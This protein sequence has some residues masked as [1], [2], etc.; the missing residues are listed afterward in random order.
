MTTIRHH[1][2]TFRAFAYISRKEERPSRDGPLVLLAA[3]FL[4][5][6]HCNG[7]AGFYRCCGRVRKKPAHNGATVIDPDRA[8][9]RKH[10]SSEARLKLK[11]VNTHCIYIPL[12][13]RRPCATVPMAPK[14]KKDPCG[15]F[16]ILGGC[17]L[18]CCRPCGRG[19]PACRRSRRSTRTDCRDPTCPDRNPRA[20]C[21]RPGCISRGL[22]RAHG[23]SQA[24]RTP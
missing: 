8:R 18:T 20:R 16:F 19:R 3:V 23:A 5:C 4:R 17:R 10:G 12:V 24:C 11:F 14:K 22:C 2:K 13:Q 9:I 7:G 6:G 15:S 21:P 1:R